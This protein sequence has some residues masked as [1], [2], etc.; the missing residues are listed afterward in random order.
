MEESHLFMRKKRVDG[1]AVAQQG[2]QQLVT[3]GP[4]DRSEQEPGPSNSEESQQ[5]ERV[6][7]CGWTALRFQRTVFSCY[8][9][10]SFL[11]VLINLGLHCTIPRC[12]MQLN[13]TAACV[14]SSDVRAAG[15]RKKSIFYWVRRF[16]GT[17]RLNINGR[18]CTRAIIIIRLF[19]LLD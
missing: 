1:F 9:Q 10:F 14:K 13:S 16:A 11:F 5:A 6:C 17:W 15:G 19:T 2:T 4:T 18:W 8:F 7:G 3:L 12:K